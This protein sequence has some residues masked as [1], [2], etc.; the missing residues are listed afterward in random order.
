MHRILGVQLVLYSCARGQGQLNR[1]ERTISH[2]SINRDLK[3]VIHIGT[4]RTSIL[5]TNMST[6]T[7]TH[8]HSMFK[9]AW[10]SSLAIAYIRDSTFEPNENRLLWNTCWGQRYSKWNDECHNILCVHKQSIWD[11]HLK[12]YLMADKLYLPL[13]R[14]SLQ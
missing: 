4:I 10:L 3:R 5:I 13:I 7:H 2:W 14:I 12:R 1:K 9:L 11:R 6:H 8:T